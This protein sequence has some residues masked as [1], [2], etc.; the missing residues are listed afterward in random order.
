MPSELISPTA[1]TSS[2]KNAPPAIQ[3][4]FSGDP[5]LDLG[6]IKSRD[7]S[8]IASAISKVIT[9]A[10]SNPSPS[11]PPRS[12]GSQPA[13]D[14]PANA[15]N[16]AQITPPV[17]PT[18]ISRP[19]AS[20]LTVSTAIS[21][22]MTQDA[23]EARIQAIE[24]ELRILRAQ[25]DS[26][27]AEKPSNRSTAHFAPISSIVS[28][29]TFAY[30]GKR[31]QAI[32]GLPQHRALQPISILAVQ[33]A[34]MHPISIPRPPAQSIGPELTH[35]TLISIS[36]H[37]DTLILPSQPLDNASTPIAPP[38]SHSAVPQPSTIASPMLSAFFS[39]SH[40]IARLSPHIPLL[41]NRNHARLKTM[42]CNFAF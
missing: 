22:P 38:I 8:A 24:D 34:A 12:Q 29:A 11:Q 1:H 25:S 15:T 23:A 18:S 32:H 42:Q 10:I 26:D 37:P 2:S 36:L 21:I 27:T 4:Q 41:Y 9:D 7:L 17:P 14:L 28:P 39:I 20:I 33:T 40:I 16:P 30:R 5:S 19:I 35:I 31:Y 13:S 3:A 6:Y